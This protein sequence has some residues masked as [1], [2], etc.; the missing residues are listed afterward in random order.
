MPPN[1]NFG[2]RVTFSNVGFAR[3]ESGMV[4]NVGIVVEIAFLYL[5]ASSYFYFQRSGRHLEFRSTSGSLRIAISEAGMI[6]N[7][8][9]PI[10]IASLFP[11][12]PKIFLLPVWRAPS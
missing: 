2:S 10:E 8:G 3:I 7:M 1:L 5:T 4:I 9:M 6:K 11:I 12:V